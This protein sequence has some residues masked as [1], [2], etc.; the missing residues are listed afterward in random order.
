MMKERFR[1]KWLIFLVCMAFMLQSLNYKETVHI[2]AAQTGTVT[3]NTLNVRTQPS[4]T[5]DKVMLGDTYVYLKKGESVTILEEAGDWYHVSLKFNG[6]TIKGYVLGDFIK[7]GTGST[8]PSPTPTPEPT[9]SPTPKP[10][11][12]PTPTQAPSQE[13]TLTIKKAFQ[14]KATVIAAS[15]NVRSG[16]GTN[17]AKVAGLKNGNSVTVINEVMNDTTKWYAISFQSGGKTLEGYVSSQY[18]KLNFETTVKGNVKA[19]KTKI[20]KN[21]GNSSA[22]L[23]NAKG[24]IISLNKGKSVTIKDE[25]TINNEKW[26]KVTF[27]LDSKKYTGYVPANQTYFRITEETVTPTPTPTPT[28]TPTPKPTASPTPTPKPTATPTPTPTPTPIATPTPTL[29]DLSQGTG[30]L[31]I[32]PIKIYDTITSPKI[33]YVCNTLSLNVFKNIF[34]SVEYLYDNNLQAI[35]L[36][37]RQKVTVT[38]ANY[39]DF[40]AWYKITFTFNSMEYSGYVRAEYIYIVEASQTTPTTTP[41]P[42]PT[43]GPVFGDIDNVDFELKLIAQG[44]PESYKNGLRKLHEKYPSWEFVAY[45]TGL[46]WNT[47]ITSESVPGRNTIPNTKS[48]EWL[49]FDK[50]A[51]DWK[52]D[53]FEVFDGKYWVT[54]SREAIEYYMDPRNFLT[55]TNIF[56]FELLKYQSKYQNK[57]GVENIL[58]GTALYNASYSFLDDLGIQQTYSYSDTFIKAAEYSGVS[59]YHLAS[60]VKQEVVTGTTTLS[61]SVSGT[62]PGYEGYYNYYNIGANDSAGGGA[63]ANGLKYAMNGK[64]AAENALYLIPWTN[65]YKSIVGGSYFLGKSYINRGQDTVYL[66]KF[67]VTPTSTYYHQYMTN[68]EAP[69]AEGRKIATAYKSMIN[70]PIVFSIPVYLNMPESA[71]PMPTT[72]FNPNNRM[73]SLKVRDISGNEL[74]I[75]PTFSQTVYNYSLIVKNEIDQVNITAGAVSKKATIAGSGNYPLAVGNNEIKLPVMA[76]NGDIAYYVIN[77]VRE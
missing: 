71:T 6:K 43:P 12:A 31:E 16:A 25:V 29:P 49:S 74:A 64:S 1:N 33:G 10:T 39:Y 47:V 67:N 59:P 8:A 58:S 17:F 28:A 75:T 61:G 21:A 56:Q 36:N 65:P 57:L 5:S 50:G 53:T 40:S 7:L 24:S 27:T 18:I 68:V 48:V 38:E 45:H 66:Q 23:K 37:N 52:T 35:F 54:A 9:P 70:S 55:D 15:L 76:E 34:N 3:A 63:I 73:K 4:T 72:K 20:R 41:T 14:H 42:T 46:D 62:Y 60:R 11:A 51:Y 44:F 32:S 77:I 13:N 2:I 30:P 26:F 69:W 22:Y 19:G